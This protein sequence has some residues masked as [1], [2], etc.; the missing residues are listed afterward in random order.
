MAPIRTQINPFYA[1]W[2]LSR[3]RGRLR[4]IVRRGKHGSILVRR[5]MMITAVLATRVPATSR[6]CSSARST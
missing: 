1:S 3:D 5:T 2:D 4:R 6:P